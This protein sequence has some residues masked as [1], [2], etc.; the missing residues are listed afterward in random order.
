MARKSN[1]KADEVQS[2]SPSKR[3]WLTQQFLEQ[4]AA[5]WAENGVEVIETLR[6]KFP[7]TYARIVA[8]LLPRV[9][10]VHKQPISG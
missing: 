9:Q 5:D 6:K 1:G 8:D 4:L 7:T 2:A 3:A 10:S